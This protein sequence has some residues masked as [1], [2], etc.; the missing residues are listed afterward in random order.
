MRI[1]F[2]RVQSDPSRLHWDI[3]ENGYSA[4]TGKKSRA[5][6]PVPGNILCREEGYY[7]HPHRGASSPPP[8]LPAAPASLLSWLIKCRLFGPVSLLRILL[9]DTGSLARACRDTPHN[10]PTTLTQY[11]SIPSERN[12]LESY[13]EECRLAGGEENFRGFAAEQGEAIRGYR[14]KGI[15]RASDDPL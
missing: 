14:A 6:T 1:E 12:A 10:F 7:I 11:L 3:T 2:F 13:V 5:T 8:R 15:P 9:G 4:M